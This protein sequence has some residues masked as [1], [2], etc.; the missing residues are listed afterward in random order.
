[1]QALIRSDSS[2]SDFNNWNL[3]SIDEM[4]GLVY[5]S[6]SILLTLS[7]DTEPTKIGYVGELPTVLNINLQREIK[8]GM[9]TGKKILGFPIEWVD[10]TTD[11]IIP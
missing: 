1:M 5:S 6:T 4:Y 10:L 11:L 7:L 3:R 9:E 2:P 8:K